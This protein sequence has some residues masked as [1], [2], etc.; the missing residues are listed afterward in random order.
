[1]HTK[2]SKKWLSAARC[3]AG[4]NSCGQ[5]LLYGLFFTNRS[6]WGSRLQRNKFS[7]YD[8]LQIPGESH[9]FTACLHRLSGVGH[10]TLSDLWTQYDGNMKQAW[11]EGPVFWRVPE[12]IKKNAQESWNR[13]QETDEVTSVRKQLE[14]SHVT[15]CL[16]PETSYPEPFRHMALAPFVLYTRGVLPESWQTALSVV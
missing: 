15:V 10:K 4:K 6:L 3:V 12:H 13:A 7:F 9:L 2:T 5:Q 16:F 1:M 14:A 8:M 11:R